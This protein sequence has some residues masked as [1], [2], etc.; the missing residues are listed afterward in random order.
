MTKRLII[1]TLIF[2]FVFGFYTN[3]DADENS[4]KMC[5][6]K[7]VREKFINA[8]VEKDSVILLNRDV[9]IPQSKGYFLDLEKG[10][11]TIPVNNG[12][13]N[14]KKKDA[15]VIS[16]KPEKALENTILSSVSG[17]QKV[18]FEYKENMPYIKL[19]INNKGKSDF[20]V[21]LLSKNKEAKQNIATD[22]KTPKP[23]D[24]FTVK[25][26]TSQIIYYFA[27][28]NSQNKSLL[29]EATSSD[30]QVLDGMMAVKIFSKETERKHN[31]HFVFEDYQ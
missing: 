28:A 23:Y 7:I 12:K 17:T 31:I 4:K 16:F 24:T 8:K 2:M 30:N 10:K 14:N 21:K 9:I 6:N 18:E 26:N 1:T 20:Q 27:D 29:V 15:D 22:S 13:A 5:C 11:T 3:A 19:W 25:A